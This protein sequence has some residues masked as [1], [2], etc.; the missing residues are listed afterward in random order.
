MK[1]LFLIFTI[2]LVLSACV[3]SMRE[4]GERVFKYQH[5]VLVEL[6]N[7]IIDFEEIDDPII[8]KLYAYEDELN[9]ACRPIQKTAT[10]KMMGNEITSEEGYEVVATMDDCYDKAIEVRQYLKG[11]GLWTGQFSE[12]M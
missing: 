7:I 10:T 12:D 3:A 5:Q 8:E 9:E 11:K 1:R 4:Y 2:V 6:M